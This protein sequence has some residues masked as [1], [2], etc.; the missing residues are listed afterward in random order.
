MCAGNRGCDNANEMKAVLGGLALQE[1]LGSEKSTEEAT[2]AVS[3]MG[4]S[5]KE[6]V[7][8]TLLHWRA[9]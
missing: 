2:M 7:Q 1:T 4:C 3:L 9:V 8:M 5:G 6:K